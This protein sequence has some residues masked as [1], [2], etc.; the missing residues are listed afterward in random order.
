MK[1]LFRFLGL[2]MGYFGT[3][4]GPLLSSLNLI[5][6]FWKV[7]LRGHLDKLKELFREFFGNFFWNH[8]KRFLGVC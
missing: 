2:F 3:S 6:N 1:R 4:Y 8:L 5:R 7:S